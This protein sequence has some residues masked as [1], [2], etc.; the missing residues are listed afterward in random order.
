[1]ALQLNGVGKRYSADVW[2]VRDVDLELDTGIHG[3]LGPNGAGKS[4]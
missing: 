4:S 1:M 2:G 3:L